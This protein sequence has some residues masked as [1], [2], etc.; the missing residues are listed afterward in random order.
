MNA[1]HRSISINTLCY[2]PAPLGIL[3][4][5]TAR[6]GARGIS[7][8]LEQVLDFKVAESARAIRDAGLAIATLTHRAF[9]FATPGEAGAARERLNRTIGV[10]AEIGAQSIIM[11]TG[12][13]GALNWN[14]AAEAFAEAIA[15]CAEA[16]NQAGIPLGIEPTSHLYADVS[17]AHRLS[18]TVEIAR[19]AGIAAM[20]DVFA[21]WVDGNLDD[22]L[23]QA[24]P[25]SRVAQIS[26]YVYGDRGLPCRAVPGDGAI[27][28]ERIVSGLVKG[29]FTGW[30]DLEIIGPRLQAEGQEAGLRRAGEYIGNLLEKAGIEP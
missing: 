25:I 18:D 6:L 24:A 23:A 20:V 5:T 1:M 2:A 15:P 13:R 17:I 4:D 29:G 10:A 14:E 3:A 27:P 30:Y 19:R 28:L 21:C 26:D 16:A 9:A 11:T 7:P 12:G 22:A 8:D